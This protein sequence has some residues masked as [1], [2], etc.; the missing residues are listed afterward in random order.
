[1]ADTEL[2]EVHIDE[3]DAE[4]DPGAGDGGGARAVTVRLA[5]VLDIG[6]VGRFREAVEP[7]LKQGRGV[8]ADL[9]EVTFCDSTGLGAIVVLHRMANAAGVPFALRSPRHRVAAVLAMTGVDQIVTV[10]SDPDAQ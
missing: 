8:V 4:T 10:L 1:M 6:T 5:G 9:S 2:L 3:T 7:Y